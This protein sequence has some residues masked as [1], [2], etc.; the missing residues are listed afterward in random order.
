MSD[1]LRL[2]AV[3]EPR[4][5]A[6]AIVLADEQVAT[7]SGG[8]AAFPVIVEINGTVLRLRV[9][10][11]KGENLIGLSKAARQEAGV[12][13]GGTYPVAISADAGERTVEVP[14]DLATALQ[15]DPT[16]DAAFAALA[17]SHRK[18]YVRW[19]TEAK[20]P[21]T[22]AER[23]ATTVTMVRDGRTR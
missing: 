5:P 16:V 13:I 11:M 8:R 21:A 9:A 6:G 7:I 19:V 15:A 22:R 2:D 17:Y 1:T 20:R 4:G 18:E 12:E 14:E 10:R 3:L 23:I